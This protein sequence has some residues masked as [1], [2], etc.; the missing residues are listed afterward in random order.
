MEIIGILLRNTISLEEGVISLSI[1]DWVIRMNVQA[2][3]GINYNA[4]FV[5]DI[6]NIRPIF[7]NVKPPS[8][9]SV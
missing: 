2:T 5:F 8:Q 6:F 4:M 1:W 7:F 3:E 9:N